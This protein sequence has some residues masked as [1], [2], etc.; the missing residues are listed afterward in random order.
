MLFRSDEIT[1]LA[2]RAAAELIKSYAPKAIVVACNTASAVALGELRRVFADT[3]IVGTVPAVKPAALSSRV[4]RIGVVATARTADDPYLLDL[5]RRWASDCAVIRRGDQELVGF[6]ERR[7]LASTREERL[8]AV[9]PSVE[10]MLNEGVDAIVLGCTHFL[11][12][13]AEFAELAGP[14]VRIVDSR[15]GVAAQIRRVLSGGPGL[16]QERHAGGDCMHMSGPGPFDAQLAAF[17]ARFGL[18]PRGSLY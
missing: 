13:A 8:E 7:L 4:K 17:A 6:V 5:V 18:E 10:A 11:H 14:G 12:L 9:R 15:D 1:A 16:A 2:L 3:P